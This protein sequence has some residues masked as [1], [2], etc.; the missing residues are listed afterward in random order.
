VDDQGPV[1]ILVVRCDPVSHDD[2]IGGGLPERFVGLGVADGKHDL[3]FLFH[4]PPHDRPLPDPQTGIVGDRPVVTSAA[5]IGGPKRQAEDLRDAQAASMSL[6][7]V[8][9]SA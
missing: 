4:E 2:P 1:C 3:S 8:L 6:D 5:F 9:R 7:H